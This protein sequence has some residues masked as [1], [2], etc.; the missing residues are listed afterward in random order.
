[1]AEDR[2]I[3]CDEETFQSLLAGLDRGLSAVDGL[4]EA[5][6]LLASFLDEVWVWDAMMF[7][8]RRGRGSFHFKPVLMT[9][10]VNGQRLP[11]HGHDSNV[12]AI[13][14]TWRRLLEGNPVLINRHV[15]QTPGALLP[16]GNTSRKSAS[17]VYVPM[18][19]GDQS[20]A[21]ISLQ[22]YTSG[23][24]LECDRDRLMQVA[25]VAAPHV[26]RCRAEERVKEFMRLGKELNRA[27]DTRGVAVTL[28]ASAL[29]LLG[30]D[31]F[32]I[33][34]KEPAS[35]QFD[36][37]IGLQRFNTHCTIFPEKRISMPVMSGL[38]K[39][40]F[41]G[42]IVK[43][44]M[45]DKS[46]KDLSWYRPYGDELP[47]LNALVAAPIR[48]M[49]Q[50][51]G[52]LCLQ[53]ESADAFAQEEQ[54]MVEVL[55]EYCSG[56]LERAWARQNL[57]RSEQNYRLLV[58]YVNDGIV[59]SQDEHFAF[60]NDQFAT[61]LG[62][63]PVELQALSYREVYTQRGLE[64]LAQRA[65]FRK[66]GLPVPDRYETWFRRKDGSVVPVEANVRVIDNFHGQPAT[67]AV[68]R[69][70]TER[71][72]AENKIFESEQELRALFSAMTDAILILDS[73]G[74][75]LNR[76]MSRHHLKFTV[77]EPLLDSCLHRVFSNEKAD[78]LLKLVK[79]SLHRRQTLNVEYDLPSVDGTV[80]YNAMISPLG[81]NSVLMV[82]RDVT[83]RRQAEEELFRSN[84]R[85]KALLDGSEDYIFVLDSDLRF[86]H[87]N[88]AIEKRFNERPESRIGVSLNELYGRRSMP[89]F[90]DQIRSVFK[91]GKPIMY[92]D[93]AIVEGRLIC[94]E[95]VISPVFSRT[96][97]VEAVLGISRDVT[98]RR[99]SALA[100]KRSEERYAGATK[101][102]NDGIWDWNLDTDKI[103]L[104]PRWWAII[105]EDDP[106]KEGE[107]PSSV[108]F[109]QVHPEDL[110]ALKRK[111][112]D[113]VN[114]LTSHVQNE[115]RMRHV[116]GEWR[117][118]LCRGLCVSDET[119]G[120]TPSRMAG[121]ISDIT[122][123]KAAESMLLYGATHDVLTNLPNR[124]H[125]IKSLQRVMTDVQHNRNNGICAVLFLDLDRFK[126]VNDSLGHLAGDDLIFETARRLE[127]C[128][129]PGDIVARM[130]GDEFTVLLSGVNKESDVTFVANRIME[131]LSQ[132]LE[133][134]GFRVQTTVSMGIAFFRPSYTKPDDLLRDAD[135][136]MYRA[137]AAGR[138]RYQI[139]DS[140]MHR[141]VMAQLQL[142]GELRQAVAENQFELYYQPIHRVVD[143]KLVGF[144]ALIRWNHPKDGLT[145][146]DK[147]IELAEETGLIL[148]IG[149]WV[150]DQALR[151]CQTWKNEFPE[152]EKLLVSVNMSPKQFLHPGIIEHI[153]FLLEGAKAE[154]SDLVIEITENLLMEDST[155]V[156]GTLSKVREM[157][158]RLDLD[159][160]GTG[161]SSLSFLRKS[162]LDMI[163]IDRSFVKDM[164]KDNYSKE[165]VSAILVLAKGMQLPVTAE[166]V[167]TEEQLQLLKEMECEFAQGYY[168][169][170][171]MP[172][173]KVLEFISREQQSASA[174]S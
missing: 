120:K 96:G 32:S 71:R 64:I 99:Q 145:T 43:G 51:I 161:Y 130:G 70:I 16:F 20:I 166:G 154:S 137:K 132:P 68:I 86:I 125:F 39:E 59:I 89:A 79:R 111:I 53:S 34:L 47:L 77:W 110:D 74:N 112:S 33:H 135:T 50:V 152:M 90:V 19:S 83:E 26:A 170:R 27:R 45:A 31:A 48:S 115:H 102:T 159:D 104:S 82:A 101:A 49:G 63:D 81:D 57:E 141:Q 119:T 117:W 95:T 80:W 25:K 148:P 107:F 42:Q 75:C 65:S 149:W 8:A 160:F 174:E 61:M 4:E 169:S 29:D 164:A 85:Y 123:R 1:M 44:G 10:T 73:E 58:D 28:C 84:A 56:A 171:P 36:R 155:G 100:L 76:E 136:A 93:D 11:F 30:W 18:I 156:A 114:G 87:V 24:F 3:N 2:T 172:M 108:W 153:E 22:S 165:I 35:A 72:E 94:T 162:P 133:I 21:V 12:A 91:T 7:S 52:V 158:I 118:V 157:G 167:E 98:N 78:Y 147:F 122:D 40:V 37:V 106:P 151:D 113:H 134:G 13:S 66:A 146:P 105:G 103:Y 14:P 67:F 6:D 38:F 46:D 131:E 60:F 150:L 92:D 17:L 69:D 143:H 88:S 5:G 41:S 54:R 173:D 168:F 129:R 144:E 97:E 23:Q 126:V 116:D 55:A 140:E 139:F 109:D 127:R 128:V 124:A 62:Y 9:D 138:N 142:E 15:E 163:K 121:S